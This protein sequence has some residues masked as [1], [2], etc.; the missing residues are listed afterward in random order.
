MSVPSARTRLRLGEALVRAGKLSQEDLERALQVQ[1]SAGARKRLGATLTELGLCS[2]EDIATALAEQLHVPFIPRARLRVVPDALEAIGI[3]FCTEHEVVPVRDESGRLRLAMA[4]P[5]GLDLLDLVRQLLGPEVG[6]A[7]ATRSAILHQLSLAGGQGD[8]LQGIVREAFQALQEEDIPDGAEVVLEA[9]AKATPTVRLVDEIL[10]RALEEGASDIHIEPGSSSISVRFR[11]DGALREA[12]EL[13]VHLLDSVVARIKVMAEMDITIR[14]TPQDGHIVYRHGVQGVDL[15]VS[16]MPTT[17]GEKCVLRVL[18]SAAGV[19]DLSELG[20]GPRVLEPLQRAIRQPQGCV[21]VTG[22]TGAGK[23]STLH[24]CLLAVRNES[25]NIVT[26]EDPVEMEIPG[27]AQVQVHESIGVT[28]ASTLRTVLRQDPDIIMVGEIRDQE[29]ADIAM[30]AALTGHLLL[31]TLHTNDAASGVTRL[32]DIG[33]DDY[34]ISSSLTLVTAQRLLRRLC[35]SCRVAREPDGLERTVLLEVLGELPDRPL[36]GPGS[37]PCP[38][39]GGRGYSGRV[40][41][42][43]ALPNEG[44]I[45]LLIARG[46]PEF[47][48]RAAASRQGARWM[49]EE[50]VN[51]VLEGTTSLQELLRVVPLPRREGRAGRRQ[52]TP[53]QECVEPEGGSRPAP[54]DLRALSGPSDYP[55]PAPLPA[56]GHFGGRRQTDAASLREFCNSVTALPACPA[57]VTRLQTVMSDPDVSISDIVGVIQS[58]PAVAARVLRI[59][60]SSSFALRR[61]VETLGQAVV[62]LGLDQLWSVTVSTCLVAAFPVPDSMQTFVHD[63]W[64][65]SVGVCQCCRELAAQVGTSKDRL[66]LAG[67]L[68][69]IGKLLLATHRPDLVLRTTE[70]ASAAGAP[71]W[72]VEYELLGFSHAD[73]GAWLLQAWNLPDILRATTAYHH[74]PEMLPGDV[75][76]EDCNLAMLV[77]LAD[78]S[79][80]AMGMGNSGDATVLGAVRQDLGRLGLTEEGLEEALSRTRAQIPVILDTVRVREPA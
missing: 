1:S 7:A 41:T 40:A 30:R 57:V 26:I 70:T 13:P 67:L 74:T 64:I 65:H 27:V 20:F 59:A 43:E 63:L 37:G 79:V 35:P 44:D 14:R 50:G 16:T 51:L 4:D 24:S 23:S 56:T 53:P 3:E 12:L 25:L 31:T 46:A 71:L 58:D 42:A 29:T 60:N 48:V 38:T 36:R 73:V 21:I 5:Y 19:Q 72:Q 69:D 10:A 33:I 32:R 6:C 62:V 68:H 80:K 17:N 8:P 34:L 47:E 61:R 18:G 66:A 78:D 22:P 54:L 2:E 77:R 15:R 76:H 28:F 11:S 75:S 49:F 39:C 9:R 55:E 45:P 52:A